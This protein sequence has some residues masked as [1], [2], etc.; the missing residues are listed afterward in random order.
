MTHPARTGFDDG[1]DGFEAD[2]DFSFTPSVR[3]EKAAVFEDAVSGSNAAY[4]A[5]GLAAEDFAADDFRDPKFA[6]PKFADLAPKAAPA[7]STP[8]MLPMDDGLL[9]DAAVPR[10][11]IH[12]FCRKPETHALCEQ[13]G[14]DRRLMRAST[15]VRSGGLAEALELYRNQPTPALIIVESDDHTT[16]L[17]A[18]L[19]KLA[20]VCDPGTKVVVIGDHNDIALYRELMRRGVSEYLVPPLQVLQL[21][22]TITTL[23]ADP[24]TPFVGR[25]L[26]F[27]GAKGGVGAST[28]AHNVAYSLAEQM[29]AATVIID[30]DLAFGTAGLDFN[31]DPIQGFAD[32]LSKP[33][34]LD[35]V[36]LDRMTAHCTERLSLFAAPASL[37][38]NYEFTAE[39]Y[40]EVLGKIRNTAPYVVL[41]LPHSWSGW[42][43][44]TLLSVDDVVIVCTP[45]LAALR[46]AKNMIE[47]IAKARPND[48]PPQLVLNQVGVPGRPEIPVKD[49]AKA[50]G[51]EPALVV[52][53]DP[54]LFGQAANNGQMIQ[55]VNAKAKAAEA[56]AQFAQH[57][58]R[59]DAPAAKTKTPVERLLGLVKRG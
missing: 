15:M 2:D 38:D 35:P 7:V 34:R 48:A 1:L 59:R 56:L 19:D 17:L 36:L 18:G 24:S 57:L 20:E 37:D 52:P 8:L 13:M 23:Y 9:G 55:E 28:L 29:Q 43:R 42:M 39:V 41:D 54:K 30:Y 6:D 40:E 11:S 50:L 26:A 45:E 46:N 58:S 10:I 12:A 25:T 16:A 31:Q 27:V 44:N 14:H 49:F 47:L 3:A 53:F 5:D 21:V 51:V 32:A 4:A 22:R 33:D